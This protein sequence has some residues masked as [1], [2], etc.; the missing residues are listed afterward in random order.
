MWHVTR[1]LLKLPPGNDSSHFHS[2]LTDQNKS[3]GHTY[4][5]DRGSR[6]PEIAPVM[7]ITGDCVDHC[8]PD[9]SSH[10]TVNSS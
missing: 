3:C 10:H 6:G 5:L 8:L 9:C 2:H 1:W 7:N 4:S